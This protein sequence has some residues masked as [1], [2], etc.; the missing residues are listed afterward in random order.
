MKMRKLFAVLTALALCVSMIAGCGS[1]AEETKVTPQAEETAAASASET[2]E[3]SAAAEETAAA[4]ETPAATEEPAEE[5]TAESLMNGYFDSI[6]DIQSMS[7]DMVMGMAMSVT[8]FEENTDVSMNMDID[9]ASYGD[10]A[11]MIGTMESDSYGE[12]TSE[13]MEQYIMSEGDTYVVYSRDADTD[14]WSKYTSEEM[15]ISKDFVPQL[16]PADFELETVNEN[17][18]EQYKASGEVDLQK[19]VESMG[20]SFG[21]LFSG[22]AGADSESLTGTASVAYYFNK[23]TK[24]LE[25]VHIDMAKAVEDMFRAMFE[26]L[27]GSLSSLGEEDSEETETPDYSSSFEISVSDFKVNLDS[28]LI[29]QGKEIVLPDAAKEAEEDDDADDFFGITDDTDDGEEENEELSVELADTFEFKDEY[30]NF[31]YKGAEFKANETTVSDFLAATGLE[32]DG[33]YEGI[34]LEQGDINL[35]V[36]TLD[37][38]YYDSI[39]FFVKNE[40]EETIDVTDSL[41]YGVQFTIEAEAAPEYSVA[42]LTPEATLDD[43][44]A[45]LG[46][47]TYG[48][49]SDFYQSYAWESEDYSSVSVSF[50]DGKIGTMSVSGGF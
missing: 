30:L 2:Q 12:Q 21:E 23:D 13:S 48:Y 41:I 47:P 1:S 9:F 31:S 14:S 45:A 11:Y 24:V 33:D 17:G 44:I 37:T 4:T 29:N 28:I 40:G 16:D 38:E 19:M 46:N 8:L 49:E 32:L 42:G 35:A 25:A 36:V 50:V 6:S 10:N 3:A 34:T 26:G 7:F 22:I 5:V 15:T 43:L 27:L 39:T 18:T 20:E